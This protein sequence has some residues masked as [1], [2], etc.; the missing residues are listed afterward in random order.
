MTAAAR[1]AGTF[2][3]GLI[4]LALSQPFAPAAPAAETKPNE[5][6]KAA[7]QPDFER[8]VA[9]IFKA[10][11]LKCHG[12]KERKGELDLR[13]VASALKGGESGTVIVPK[14]PE[15][16]LLY[17]KVL[18]GEMPPGKKD[19]L[20][21]AELVTIRRWI[22]AGA[23]AT[24]KSATDADAEAVQALNQHDVIPILLRRCTVCHGARQQEAQLDL[25]TKASMLRGGKSGPAI[26]PGK[27]DESLLIKKVR[28]GEM[29]P[30]TRLI[31]V[32]IKPIEPAEIEI[33]A[34]W[35]AQGAPEADVKPDVATTE[36]D[37]LVSDKDR[38]F[39]AFQ[40]PAAV[41]P[42]TVKNA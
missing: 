31:E 39:W 16:S 35:I 17:E 10:K 20:S 29:P 40:P 23:R 41:N 19:R 37:A 15:K 42:P 33:V 25:R 11:C 26:V 1:L 30:L 2:I 4:L 28:A 14:D 8:D 34:R 5:S 3:A 21:E 13:T 12:E 24:A 32:S 18:E 7:P 6:G 38:D 9:P 22:E 36:P 27:P